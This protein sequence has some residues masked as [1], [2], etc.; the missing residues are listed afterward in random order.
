MIIASSILILQGNAFQAFGRDIASFQSLCQRCQWAVEAM[1][2][3]T[4]G[5]SLSQGSVTHSHLVL[6]VGFVV[7]KT[8][9]IETNSKIK[10]MLKRRVSKTMTQERDREI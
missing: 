3:G 9:S 5:A 7:Q 4:N 8:R 6:L 1:L 10:P 2:W